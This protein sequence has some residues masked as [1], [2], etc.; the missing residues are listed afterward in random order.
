MAA[1]FE[2]NEDNGAATG[3]PAKGTTR[4][5]AVAQCNYKNIDDATT[6]YTSN[7][8]LAGSNSF[9]KWQC[10]KFSGTY[11][12]ILN[13][14]WAHTAGVLGTGLTLKGKASPA[15]GYTTP[16]VTANANLTVDMTSV[17]AI[18]SG[19]TV[20][21]GATGPEAAGKAAS[22]SANPAYTDFLVSQLQTTGAAVPGDTTSITL[23]LQYDEN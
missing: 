18:G 3:S 7:P 10:G 21:F 16:A 19:Q 1:T 20:Q 11:N 13:G 8:I 6:P 2:F 23:M 12:Q 14:K 5:T 15:G 22:T 17:I 4:A 9:D